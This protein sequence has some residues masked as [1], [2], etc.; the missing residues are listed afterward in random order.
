MSAAEAELIFNQFGLTADDRE[1]Y[2]PL[3]GR[4]STVASELA[5]MGK[6]EY[7]PIQES[8][9]IPQ[10]RPVHYAPKNED[11]YRNHWMA[12]AWI[13]GASFRMLAKL[14]GISAPTVV[15]VIDRFLESGKRNGMRL[16]YQL[17]PDKISEY[18]ANYYNNKLLLSKL[19][20]V[21]AAVWLMQNTT[22][23]SNAVEDAYEEDIQR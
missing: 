22:V 6:E 10:L 9:E 15:Q 19:S 4:G 23:D 5:D 18:H 11:R 8:N 16:G 3:V 14:H 2:A 20:V 13:L 21:A 12:T 7:L 17:T 1:R